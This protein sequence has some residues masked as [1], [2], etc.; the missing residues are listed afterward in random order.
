[1]AIREHADSQTASRNIPSGGSQDAV[2]MFSISS[3]VLRFALLAALVIGAGGVDLTGQVP[4][5]ALRETTNRRSEEVTHEV[6]GRV[7]LGPVE[8]ELSARIAAGDWARRLASRRVGPAEFGSSWIPS[9]IER[10]VRAA[11]IGSLDPEELYLVRDTDLQ[12]R[13]H[14]GYRSYQCTV[15]V[16]PDDAALDGAVGSLE[17]RFDRTARRLR[18]ILLGT[19]VFWGLL[20]LVHGWFDRVTRGYMPWRGR[21]AC[22]LMAVAGPAAALS[23]GLV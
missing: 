17:E 7:E 4:A 14:G 12:A 10:Q 2:R 11:W 23:W 22:V 5:A 19:P 3:R 6:V 8:A 15:W 16:S 13:D 21:L 1:V 18:N 20:A 9:V